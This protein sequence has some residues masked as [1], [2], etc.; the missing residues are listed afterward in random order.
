MRGLIIVVVF[1][2]ALWAETL[3]RIAVTVGAH[4]IAESEILNNLRVVAFIDEQAPDVSLA[5]RRAAAARLVDQYLILE[6]AAIT[7]ALLP[8]SEE[9]ARLLVP[10]RERYASPVLFQAALEQ[11]GLSEAD[12]SNHLLNG[13]RLLRYSENRFRPQVNVTEEDL[14][15]EYEKLRAKAGPSGGDYAQVHEQLLQFVTAARVGE[16]MD[17]WLDNTRRSVEIQYREAVFP[18]GEAK[19]KDPSARDAKQGQ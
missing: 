15:T 7:R 13:L 19:L 6:D 17:E 4:V 8:R 18:A 16:A 1:S 14:R 3:D 5:G 10:F 9:L 11:A 2:L 12:L